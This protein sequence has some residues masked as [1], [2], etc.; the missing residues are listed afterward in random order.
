MA[1]V[2]WEL[3]SVTAPVWAFAAVAS[4]AV[5]LA[6]LGCQGSQAF[7]A[8]LDCQDRSAVFPDNQGFPDSPARFLD[9][10][11]CLASFPVKDNSVVAVP[12]RCPALAN[13]A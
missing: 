6:S 10:S 4:L 1:P 3:A 7:L 5:N 11:V 12:A 13:L 2:A 9:R 8:N